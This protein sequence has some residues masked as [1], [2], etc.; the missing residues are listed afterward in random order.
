MGR[1]NRASRIVNLIIQEDVS[2]CGVASLAMV[3]G[4]TYQ[5]VKAWFIGCNFGPLG[6]LSHLDLMFFLGECGIHCRL[7]YRWLP[8]SLEGQQRQR[9]KWP[10]DPI[11]SIHIIG[12]NDGRHI[13]VWLIDGTVL[14]PQSG[15]RRIEQVGD[16]AYVLGVWP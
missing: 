6:G 2:G 10:P 11:A 5:D 7:L 1:H 4:R 3:T 9:Q 15:S 12:I 8:G 14:D 13:A 16:I